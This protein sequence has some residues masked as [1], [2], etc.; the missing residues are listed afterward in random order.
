MTNPILWPLPAGVATIPRL[1][2]LHTLTL[3]LTFTTSAVAQAEI[4]ILT[5]EATYT[6]GDG[7]SPSFAEAMV[8]Q[9]AKQVALEQA[10]TYVERY[11]KVQNYNLT[12]EE[13]Q[14]IAGGVL[15]VEVLEKTR[16]LV[17][18]GLRFFIRIK[19]TVTTD[20]MEELARRIKGKNAAEEYKKLQEDY[21]RLNKEIETWKQL[22]AKTPPGPEHEAALDQ[23]RERE[24]A[25][26][27]VQSSEAAF[28]R[29]LV[30]GEALVRSAQDERAAV[31]ALF[32]K[33]VKQGHVISLGTPTS[34]RTK[35]D[36]DK[37]KLLIPVTLRVSKSI[38][39][40]ME[41]TAQSLGGSAR[42]TEFVRQS[43]YAERESQGTIIR[44]GKDDEVAWYFW[45]RVSRLELVVTLALEDGQALLCNDWR[46]NENPRH[47]LYLETNPIVPV[48]AIYLRSLKYTNQFGTTEVIRDLAKEIKE[49]LVFS[50]D[51]TPVRWV[52]SNEVLF[53]GTKEPIRRGYSLYQVEPMPDPSVVVFEDVRNFIVT[54][55]IPLSQAT[56]IKSIRGEYAEKLPQAISL[57]ATEEPSKKIERSWWERLFKADEE[58]KGNATPAPQEKMVK[59]L[60]CAIEP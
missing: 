42:T 44:M 9:K 32:Q 25:F 22:I 6:M 52:G 41:E 18:E 54:T 13:I 38:R 15:Q 5:A 30:S 58:T 33:I 24:R 28:F 4:Q 60:I 17:G 47:R 1:L 3:I 59:T 45:E 10:G 55:V 19:A 8:L 23:I 7:E 36:P 46:E 56:H 12:A 43:Q 31:D 40:A 35:D 50:R 20:K 34:H 27:A 21:A 14:T 29:R 48:F 51:D 16:T 57:P 37:V 11:T 53:G 26:S 49:G 39:P 2:F